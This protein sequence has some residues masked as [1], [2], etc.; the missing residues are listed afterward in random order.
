M[1]DTY[2][3]ALDAIAIAKNTHEEY[4]GDKARARRLIGQFLEETGRGYRKTV[5][6][7]DGSRWKQAQRYEVLHWRMED[8]RAIVRIERVAVDRP[9]YRDRTRPFSV[10]FQE[11]VQRYEAAPDD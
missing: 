6:H 9:G 11:F 4:R 10:D 5:K 2:S 3:E 8:G 1:T 7:S